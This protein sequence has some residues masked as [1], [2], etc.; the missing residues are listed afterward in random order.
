MT[1]SLPARRAFRDPDYRAWYMHNCPDET[2]LASQRTQSLIGDYPLVSIA[3]PIWRPHSYMLR[4]MLESL[5]DQSYP[6]WEACLVVTADEDDENIKLLRQFADADERFIINELPR[7][8]GIGG[9]TNAAIA[10]CRGDW[11]AFVD[12]DDALTPDALFHVVKAFGA[13]D[14]VYSDFDYIDDRDG[15]LGDPLFKPEWSPELLYAANYLTH[16]TVVRAG[17]L[18]DIGGMAEDLD[19]AQDW[20]LHLRLAERTQRIIHV[21]RV[22]YHWRRHDGSTA[23]SH[24]AKEGVGRSQSRSL[25]RHFSRKGLPAHAHVNDEGHVRIGWRWPRKPLASIIIPTKDKVDLLRAAISSIIERTRYEAIEIVVVDTGSCNQ[26]TFAYYEELRRDPRIRILDYALPFNWSAVNNFAVR[27][28]AGELLIFLNNDV[29][30]IDGDWVDELAGW[31]LHPEIGAVG[32]LLLRANGDVQH[33]GIVVGLEGFANHPFADTAVS[34]GNAHGSPLWYRN[35]L[36]VTG[37]CLAVRRDVFDTVGGFDEA[38][39]LCGSDVAFGIEAY[40]RGFRNVY[41]PYARLYHLES[42]TRGHEIPDGD[43]AVSAVYYRPYLE[44]GDPYFSPNLSHWR[45]PLAPRHP[46]EQT[47]Y[48]YVTQFLRRRSMTPPRSRTEAEHVVEWFDLDESEIAAYRSQP[49]TGLR[50]TTSIAWF[51]PTFTVAA[52]GGIATILRFAAHFANTYHVNNH[53][54]LCGSGDRATYVDLMRRWL[55]ELRVDDVTIGDSTAALQDVPPCDAAICSLWT[56]AYALARFQRTPRKFY[57]I[58]DWE[59]GF[60]AAGTTSAMV[61]NTYRLGF[62]GIANTI[63]LARSY[64]EEFGG[65]ATWFTPAVDHTVFRPKAREPRQLDPLRTRR[66]F[67]YARPGTPRNAF[68]LIC[69][70]VRRLRMRHGPGIELIAAGGDFSAAEYQVAGAITS[71]GLLPFEETPALY[72]SC[73]V[74]VALMMTRHPSY[75]PLELMASGCPVVANVNRWNS[76]FYRDGE[77]AHLALPSPSG[78]ADAVE[79]VAFDDLYAEKLRFGGFETIARFHADWNPEMDHVY[80]F[81]CDPETQARS[82]DSARFRPSTPRF[83]AG[84]A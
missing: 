59:P 61:E 37:A 42:A 83:A 53:F 38:F 4:E 25:N 13:A 9:N 64:A 28:S 50:P 77:N 10:A 14:V 2:E 82:L 18:R 8:K 43:F 16:L 62:Y 63:S 49:T 80:A 46:D 66:V 19:G 69:A 71:L 17:L 23:L 47:P 51:L 40:R 21:P 15:S 41:T 3:V 72:R 44:A 36:A 30:V 1:L 29:E 5:A 39:I 6:Y 35:Y 34:V 74:G 32:A 26:T 27:H 75:I 20:D 81:L 78:L 31:A 7:N 52:F 45:K 58:Q 56:T 11:I 73:D 76:W 60:Y 12:H 70:A 79:R 24:R 33:A 55:P 68:E 48:D 67:V 84:R 22:L 65:S 57:F 54:V